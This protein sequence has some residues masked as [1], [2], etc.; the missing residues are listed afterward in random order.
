[1][2]MTY[3]LYWKGDPYLV[4]AYQKAHEIKLERENQERWIQGLY[5]YRAFKSVIDAF[6]YGLNHC[7][8]PRPS[9][10]PSEPLPFTE[11]EKMA[12]EKRNKEQAQAWL[13]EDDVF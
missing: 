3:E 8:G 4:R 5:N 7:K 9:E 13:D 1:M 6:S 10:Y 11:R 12:A 2:G